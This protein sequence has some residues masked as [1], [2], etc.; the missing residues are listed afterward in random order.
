MKMEHTGW[1]A[2]V[3]S[4]AQ[5][6]MRSGRI[7]RVAQYSISNNAAFGINEV[8]TGRTVG[9]PEQIVQWNANGDCVSVSNA[10]AK[11]GELLNPQADAQFDLVESIRRSTK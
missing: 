1:A 11:I 5:Y 6:K 2:A 10:D 7:A 4:Q 9:A 8:I 3:A